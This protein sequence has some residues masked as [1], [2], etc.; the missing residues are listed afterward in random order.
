[1]LRGLASGASAAGRAHLSSLAK[2]FPLRRR[3][4]NLFCAVLCA[5]RKESSLS[6]P[7]GLTSHKREANKSLRVCDPLRARPEAESHV[8]SAQIFKQCERCKLTATSRHMFTMR[9]D[10]AP[11]MS[12]NS[13]WLIS[14]ILLTG[15]AGWRFRNQTKKSTKLNTKKRHAQERVS[16]CFQHT[17][18]S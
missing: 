14:A 9:Q 13:R 8:Q 17:L 18:P 1:L 2:R 5:R 7:H 16:G 15:P 11:W 10:D 6:S 3:K 4:S 12:I